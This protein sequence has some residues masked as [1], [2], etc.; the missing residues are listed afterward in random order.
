MIVRH[1]LIV[2]AVILLENVLN[3]IGMEDH[4]TGTE[5]HGDTDHI[6]VALLHLHEEAEGIL[7]HVKR[8]VDR[9]IPC[10]SRWSAPGWLVGQQIMNSS[11]DWLRHRIFLY[12]CSVALHDAK[13]Q[14]P[15]GANGGLTPQ[16][17]AADSHGLLSEATAFALL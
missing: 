6:R 4:I 10:R 11:E 13:A 8:I 1:I 5:E 17:H 16:A 14:E 2:V 3:P 15:L 9:R 12:V 7:Q